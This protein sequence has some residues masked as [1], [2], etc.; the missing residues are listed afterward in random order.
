MQMFPYSTKWLIKLSDLTN[1][2]CS[3]IPA[4]TQGEWQDAISFLLSGLTVNSN[5]L[6]SD[7]S[8]EKWINLLCIY[9]SWKEKINLCSLSWNAPCCLVVLWPCLVLMWF[10]SGM[11]QNCSTVMKVKFMCP[12]LAKQGC[13]GVWN[14]WS[15]LFLKAGH[16]GKQISSKIQLYSYRL[17]WFDL[18]SLGL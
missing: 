18:Q 14:Q 12:H 15:V 16:V 9:L 13:K 1:L 6:I 17:V 11:Q 2:T 7:M 8:N 5:H 10:V 3:G 4:Q